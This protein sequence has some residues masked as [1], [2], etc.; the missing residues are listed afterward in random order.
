MLFCIVLLSLFQ[1]TKSKSSDCPVIQSYN[2]SIENLVITHQTS[3]SDTQSKCVV[4]FKNKNPHIF[5]Y[6]LT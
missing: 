5:N 4:E 1:S 3:D 6:I 2:K